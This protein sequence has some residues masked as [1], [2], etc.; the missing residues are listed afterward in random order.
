M[1]I[2]AAVPERSRPL[3]AEGCATRRSSSTSPPRAATENDSGRAARIESEDWQFERLILKDGREFWGLTQVAGEDEIEFAEIFRRPG[4]PMSAVVRVFD[5]REIQQLER[6]PAE[7]F[8]LLRERFP[9]NW[10]LSAARAAGAVRYLMGQ[11]VDPAR[12][13]VVGHGS[14]RPLV[15]GDDYAPNRRIEILVMPTDSRCHG[16]QA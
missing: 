5:A 16:V 7:Q 3:S 11:G 1:P 2:S 14:T 8:E 12:L 6:L 10:E 9:T 4:R 13:R 15:A